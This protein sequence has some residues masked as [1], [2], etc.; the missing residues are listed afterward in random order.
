MKTITPGDTELLQGTV[1]GWNMLRTEWLT[2]ALHRADPAGLGTRRVAE[3]RD[4][5]NAAGPAA[6][7]VLLDPR[8][9]RWC[10]EM[11][12]LIERDAPSLLPTGRFH[13]ACRDAAAFTLAARFLHAQAGA[14][15]GRAQDTTVRVD[16]EGR[17]R[18]PGTGWVLIPGLCHA[19]LDVTI[20]VRDGRFAVADPA[21][22]GPVM[23]P[24][25]LVLP[26]L[27]I[28][29][30]DPVDLAVCAAEPL[31]ANGPPSV[32]VERGADDL[33]VPGVPGLARVPATASPALR[34]R[35]AL[36]AAAHLRAA[37]QG[38]RLFEPG[39]HVA[40]P[41]PEVAHLAS[42]PQLVRLLALHGSPYQ[43]G[44]PD[45]ASR[46]LN[47]LAGWL[48]SAGGLSPLGHEL[49][50][51]LAGSG[52][53]SR[54]ADAGPA[55]SDRGEQPR[56]TRAWRASWAEAG[57]TFRKAGPRPDRLISDDP[58]LALLIAELGGRDGIEVNPISAGRPRA[59]PTI[60]QLSLI[61]V[62]TPERYVAVV[63]RS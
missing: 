33:R 5:L 51:R 37:V 52:N 38:A 56:R 28:A 54:P 25:A 58:D 63:G 23:E 61:K 17:V 14:S 42:A 60:D 48:A 9:G 11:A 27:V 3:L 39:S 4:A 41:P 59:D 32:V 36:A 26:G 35:H 40:D 16:H 21:S 7:P 43:P 1:R 44:V 45:E 13:A 8:F 31:L 18:V 10:A 19:G 29:E 6:D 22:S 49:L 30:G 55:A 24:E 46:V 34:A 53:R 50:T 2:R 12:S 62:R 15:D 57:G 20:T 47:L